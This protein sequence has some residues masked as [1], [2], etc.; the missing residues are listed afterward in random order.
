MSKYAC[1]I[2]GKCYNE[3]CD[4]YDLLKIHNC[5]H[6]PFAIGDTCTEYIS[7]ELW[8]EIKIEE[9]FQNIAENQ[10]L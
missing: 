1:F 6:G 4:N 5:K 9:S 7:F 2:V 10:S 8:S 3:N